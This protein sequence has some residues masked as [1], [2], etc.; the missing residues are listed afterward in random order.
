V[1]S[2]KWGLFRI[3]LILNKLKTNPM[4]HQQKII[5]LLK[6]I[7]QTLRD[8]LGP[9]PI[10]A[11]DEEWLDRK[12]VLDYLRISSSTYHRRVREGSLVPVLTP[13]GYRF[14]K[15]ALLPLHRESIRRGRI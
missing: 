9:R 12:E 14:C 6:E 11:D 4:N 8:Y 1:Q 7:S 10:L 2:E 5:S 3:H 13:L 15:S